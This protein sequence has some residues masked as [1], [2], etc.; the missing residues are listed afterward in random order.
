MIVYNLYEGDI[1][2]RTIFTIIIC[3][4]AT[5]ILIFDLIQSSKNKKIRE[6]NTRL[7][8]E[9]RKYKELEIHNSK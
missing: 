1:M 8:E 5:G 4:L 7:Q 2:L 6:E 9:L 3:T